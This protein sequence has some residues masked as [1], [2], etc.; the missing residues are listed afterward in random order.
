[1]TYALTNDNARMVWFCQPVALAISA[2]VDNRLFSAGDVLEFLAQRSRGS[3][4]A[5]LKAVQVYYLKLGRGGE[6][7]DDSIAHGRARIGWRSTPLAQIHAG[8]WSAI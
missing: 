6:W 3:L 5:M 8:Q 1:M 2:V 7:A 4:S